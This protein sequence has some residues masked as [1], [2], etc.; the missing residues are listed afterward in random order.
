MEKNI[1]GI[2]AISNHEYLHHGQFIVMFRE[3]G[4]EL[5]ERFKKAWA[6]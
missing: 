3:A 6:L 4:I 5:P 1:D 2:L